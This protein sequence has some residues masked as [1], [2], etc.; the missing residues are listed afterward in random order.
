MAEASLKGR[1]DEAV[2]EDHGLGVVPPE[3]MKGE[4]LPLHLDNV[5]EGVGV[6]RYGQEIL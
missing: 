6:L 5:V 1:P 3:V 2:N 4:E